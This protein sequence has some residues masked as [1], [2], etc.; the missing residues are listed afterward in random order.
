MSN[1]HDVTCM[2]Y[3]ADKDTAN[4]TAEC[5]AWLIEVDDARN[6][7]WIQCGTILF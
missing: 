5:F 3:R 4:S 7:N 2:M 6:V 1:V